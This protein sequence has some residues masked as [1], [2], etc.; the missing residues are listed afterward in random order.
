[1]VRRT[2]APSENI[3]LEP[4]VLVLRATLKLALIASTVVPLM[5]AEVVNTRQERPVPAPAP[6]IHNL[7]P[8]VILVP[9]MI[10]ALVPTELEPLVLVLRRIHKPAPLV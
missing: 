7:V 4:L 3:N 2:R 1:V 8:I 6:R 10:V 5:T 9:L